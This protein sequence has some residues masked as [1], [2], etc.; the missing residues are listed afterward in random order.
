MSTNQNNKTAKRMLYIMNTFLLLVHTGLLILF[1]V[2]HVTLMARVNIISVLCY[3]VSFLLIKKEKMTEYIVLAFVEITIH[4]FL[5]VISTGWNFGFQLYFIGCVG[6]VF[7]ADYFSVHIGR[8]RIKG[9]GLSIPSILLYIISFLVVTFYGSIYQLD[10]R[11]AFI[12]TIFNSLIALGFATMIFSL[13][14]KAATFYEAELEKQATHDKLTG[15]KNR[16]FLVEQLGNIYTSGD[17]ASHWLAILDIDNFKGINDKYGHLCGDF[18]LR[19][20]A[21]IIKESCSD[22]IACRW[23][24]EEFLIVGADTGKDN[25]HRNRVPALL[26][27]IRRSIADKDFVY[28]DNIV[29]HLTVTIGVARYR[30]GQT[31]DE[32]INVADGRL[33]D[34]KQTGKNKVVGTDI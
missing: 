12:G 24:G 10:E 17:I 26:E 27:N 30:N 20:V 8:R 29:I 22:H 14:T 5:A 28:N 9:F 1:T 31:V 23:G 4:S 2:L 13:L 16:H 33:Y 21:E 7:F 15:M 25:E 18:V 11:I 3:I 19:T 34:G 6:V 32:W